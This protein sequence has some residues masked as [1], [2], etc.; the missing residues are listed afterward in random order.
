[1]H[2]G[3]GWRRGSVVGTA[4]W[5]RAGWC[6]VPIPIEAREFPVLQNVQ[7]NSGAQT[8]LLFNV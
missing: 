6:G 4:S 5:L 1:M 2:T 7:T 8:S 3:K